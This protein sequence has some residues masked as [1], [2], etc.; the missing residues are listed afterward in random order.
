[1]S[2]SRD[3]IEERIKNGTAVVDFDA[4]RRTGVEAARELVLTHI[5][6]MR[7]RQ[8]EQIHEARE[9]VCG[10]LARDADPGDVVNNHR[11]DQLIGVAAIDGAERQ[12][13]ES[14]IRAFDVDGSRSLEFELPE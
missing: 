5:V 8:G 4:R 12:A 13:V 14:A 11:L 6:E 3:L 9:A 7:A 10:Q 1:M 2:K